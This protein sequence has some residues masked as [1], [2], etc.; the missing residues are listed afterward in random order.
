[1]KF[2]TVLLVL[3]LVA[4]ALF[5]AINWDVFV[6]PS[7]LSLGFMQVQAPLGLV[8]LVVTG[9]VCGLFL[10]YILFQQA[11]LIM[12]TRRYAKELKAHRELADSAEA[13]RFT[14]L[15]AFLEAELRRLEAQQAAATREMGARM[16]QL[17]EHLRQARPHV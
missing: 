7:T 10:T 13:S 17:H 12:E 9:A 3:M 5:A 2:R 8:M 1:M 6:T 14:E 11:G 15:R 16:D 4:L